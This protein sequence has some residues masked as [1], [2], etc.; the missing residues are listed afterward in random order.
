MANSVSLKRKSL[1]VAS[2]I[3]APLVVLTVLISCHSPPSLTV[4]FENRTSQ[5]L[6]ASMAGQSKLLIEPHST[7]MPTTYIS[8]VDQSR[9]PIVITTESGDVVF[10]AV[11]SKEDLEAEP[12]IIDKSM[13]SGG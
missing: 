4:T 3:A 11:M 10:E 2:A 12:I 9:I 8:G 13:L 6:F 7:R 1:G 5:P